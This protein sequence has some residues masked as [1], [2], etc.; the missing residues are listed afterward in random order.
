VS[1]SRPPENAAD[2]RPVV[3]LLDLRDTPLDPAEVLAAVEDSEAGGVNL[4]VGVVR[5]H[6]GGEEVDHLDYSA[7]PSALDRMRAVIDEVAAEY[8]V[9]G[10]AAVHRVGALRIGDPAVLVAASAVH[11]GEAYDASRA[12]IDRLKATT[13]IWKHQVFADGRDEWVGTP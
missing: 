10:L 11:R 6:D 8:D 2:A 4:F 13:P 3:R 7:H 5:D 9:I 12:L 1:P